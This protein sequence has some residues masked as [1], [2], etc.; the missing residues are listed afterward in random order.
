MCSILFSTKQP[1]GINIDNLNY[2]NQ[3]RGP[4]D[5]CVHIDET[6]GFMFIHN[7]LSM[8]GKITQQPFIDGN[9]ICLYNGEIY[10]YKDFGNYK[11]DGLCLIDLYMPHHFFHLDLLLSQK[12][13][14]LYLDFN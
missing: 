3:F 13:I 4:D 5:T 12:K 8:T 14:Q 7:L 1:N 2:Y 6:N 11:S 10:N 9:I